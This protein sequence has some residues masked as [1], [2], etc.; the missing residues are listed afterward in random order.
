MLYYIIKIK[1]VIILSNNSY[2]FF[3]CIYSGLNWTNK[4]FLRLAN[5]TTI[6]IKFFRFVF[7]Q[8]TMRFTLYLSHIFF[9]R[10]RHY[11]P[12]P[13]KPSITALTI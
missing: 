11:C 1:G 6:N 9:Y 2:C 13:C 4:Y 8:N 3:Y 10:P 12:P 5:F 7:L